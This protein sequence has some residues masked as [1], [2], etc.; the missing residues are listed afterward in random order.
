MIRSFFGVL[1]VATL[2]LGGCAIVTSETYSHSEGTEPPS[3]FTY[4]LPRVMM[5]IEAT[6][7]TVTPTSVAKL[8]QRVAALTATANTTSAATKKADATRK[9]KKGVYEKA[10]ADPN[11]DTNALSALKK[12][13]D[14]A[15]LEY[16]K[17][18]AASEYAKSLAAT[19]RADLNAQRGN[20]NA[21]FRSVTLT[22]LPIEADTG[23]LFIAKL[24]HMWTRADELDIKSNELG[25]LESTDLTSED[26]LGE[27]AV[28]IAK[29]VLKAQSLGTLPA[30]TEFDSIGDTPACVKY[31]AN[32]I[33]DP[34]DYKKGSQT[35]TAIKDLLL[36]INADLNIPTAPSNNTKISSDPA[37]GIYYRRSIPFQFDVLID[38]K[39]VSSTR[40]SLPNG[41]PIAVAP[42]TAGAFVTTTRNL[43]F[44][45]G[46][47][48]SDHAV[49]PSEV[50]GLLK[51]PAGILNAILSPE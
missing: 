46:M 3:G 4:F 15:N 1:V 32:W 31:N 12:E 23:K 11:F 27:I 36:S 26:K 35:R 47:L 41:G 19:A 10:K 8:E 2:F 37:A 17:K 40:E 42:L 29:L 34:A 50:E 45:N 30:D 33:F 25:L 39:Q 16:F 22:R 9:E 38:N 14:K 24:N 51:I 44:S 7:N 43:R 5:K 21:C 49:R 18:S 6:R 20:L 13:Y 48:I 28:T